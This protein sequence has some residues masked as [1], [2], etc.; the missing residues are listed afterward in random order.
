MPIYM[1]ARHQVH[2]QAVDQTKQSIRDLV[3][4]VKVHEPL[5]T[6]YIAQQEIVNPFKFM[7][8]LK[9]E[10][11]TALGVHQNSPASARF[12]QTV[13]PEMQEPAEFTEYN[14]VAT[15]NQ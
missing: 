11:E 1:T 9:F 14:L 10:D 5:T 4:H 7:H 15:I 8:I 2:P 12:V 13:Y 3:E 6:L